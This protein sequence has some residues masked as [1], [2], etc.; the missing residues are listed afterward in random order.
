MKNKIKVYLQYPWKFPDSPYYK[1][2]IDSSLEGIEF[3][4]IKKQKGVITNKNFF[5]FSNFLKN[6]IRIFVRKICPQIPNVH[7]SP[8]GD[9]DLIHC[10][11]C[12]SKNKDKPWI[13]DIET[14]W[15][16]WVSAKK[17]LSGIKKVKKILERNN[18]KKILPWTKKVE[19][20]LLYHFPSVK[21]KIE[22]LYPAVPL[23]KKMKKINE[24]NLVLLFV[25]RYFYWKGGLHT[26][27]VMNIL[28]KKYPNIRAIF[29]S[30]VPREIKK[31]YSK[32]KNIKIYG[33]MKQKKVFKL[34]NESDIFIYPGYTDSFG[35]AY[36]EAMAFGIPTVTIDGNSR[37]ELIQDGKTGFVLIRPNK[38]KWD[39]IGKI[40]NKMINEMV[41]KTS[42]LIEDKKL[43]K[44]MS[45]ECIK[46]IQ[47]GKF[48]I[49]ERNKKIK[50]IYEEAVI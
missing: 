19:K 50:K 9:H 48:S 39:K 8:K 40:E 17:T 22:V 26:L 18:C 7:L 1:Y 4:N 28:T 47:D 30:E 29:V 3:Q 10:A 5:L 35:F 31:K 33:L 36:L 6:H 46:V 27:E 43:L 14:F 45:E 44:K 15:Q 11:H 41:N 21:E 24:K 37:K 38:F 34:Y 12:L 23:K 20:E 42:K 13:A 2:L 16:L 49:K 32:N 25:G